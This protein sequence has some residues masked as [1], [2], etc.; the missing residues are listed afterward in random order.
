MPMVTVVATP[1]PEGPPSRNDDRMTAR[2]AAIAPA[3]HGGEREVDE[4]LAGPEYCRIA[5]KIVNR[6]M[7][8]EDTSTVVPKMPS[9]VM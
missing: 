8:L 4:K 7:R 2:P 5:P 3:A 1:E 6:M 9:S